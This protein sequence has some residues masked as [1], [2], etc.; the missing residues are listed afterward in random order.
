M[1]HSSHTSFMV[2]SLPA[3][4]GPVG[5]LMAEAAGTGGGCGRTSV[6]Y[7]AYISH[8]SAPVSAAKVLLAKAGRKLMYA[9]RTI[10]LGTLAPLSM[11]R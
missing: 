7:L 5:G 1:P 9:N 6:S 8:K 10:L 11:P 2:W 4:T 3:A